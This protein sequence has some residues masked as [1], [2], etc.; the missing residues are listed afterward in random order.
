MSGYSIRSRNKPG[1]RRPA[2]HCARM[3]AGS[4]FLLA[5]LMA[6]VGLQAAA[7]GDEGTVRKAAPGGAPRVKSKLA[8]AAALK[9]SAIQ[10]TGGRQDA[11]TS[12]SDSR[13]PSK[14]ES[15]ATDADVPIADYPAEPVWP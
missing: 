7:I 11:S 9:K 5:T 10:L 14:E 8:T 13:D 6:L 2:W 4:G 1:P 3:W 15:D 12:Q